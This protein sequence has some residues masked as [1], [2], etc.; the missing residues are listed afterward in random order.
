MPSH[1]R[2]KRGIPTKHSKFTLCDSRPR[3]NVREILSL[4]G[5]TRSIMTRPSSYRCT[6]PIGNCQQ[7]MHKMPAYLVHI[8]N[9]FS[10]IIDPL[11]HPFLTRYRKIIQ[12]KNLI[13]P[14]HGMRLKQSII[15]LVSDKAP[16]LNSVPHNAFKALNNKNITWPLLFYNQFWNGQ[17]DFREWHLGQ[18]V[19]IPPKGNTYKPNKWIKVALVDTGNKIYSRI[20]CERLFKIIRKH[21]VKLQF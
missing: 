19:P 6:H 8:L 14:F 15:K 2:K 10:T 5:V 20:M 17:A 21:G 12:W 13:H 18:V 11:I 3:K 16:E 9:W 1:L 4:L 7:L